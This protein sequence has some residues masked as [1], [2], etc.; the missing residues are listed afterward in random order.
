[1]IQ[2]VLKIASIT[3]DKTLRHEDKFP[4]L[5]LIT[6]GAKVHDGDC[7]DAYEVEGSFVIQQ[8]R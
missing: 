1:M 5:K 7:C 4:R 8:S 3:R 6:Y 2:C